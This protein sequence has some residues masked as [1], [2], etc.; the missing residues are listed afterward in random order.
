MKTQIILRHVRSEY[1]KSIRKDYEAHK[2]QAGWSDIRTLEPRL[3]GL[4]NTL[5]TV[6]KDNLV[7]EVTDDRGSNNKASDKSRENRVESRGGWLILAFLHQKRVGA[8]FKKKG[9][10]AL[11]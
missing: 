3:D 1:G 8:G 11:R 4:S 2:T 7:L 6:L 5:T 10:Y 9:M